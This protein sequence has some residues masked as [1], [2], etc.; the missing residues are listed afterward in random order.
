MTRVRLSAALL[1]LPLA[2]CVVPSPVACP[3]GVPPRPRRP[4]RR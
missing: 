4:W 2:A 1:L 3:S